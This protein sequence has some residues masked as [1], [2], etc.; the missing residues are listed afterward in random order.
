[1]ALIFAVGVVISL[2]ASLLPARSATRVPMLEA[3]AAT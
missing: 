1:V 3:M 2:L